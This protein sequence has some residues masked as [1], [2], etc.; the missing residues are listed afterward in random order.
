MPSRTTLR[1]IPSPVNRRMHPLFDPRRIERDALHFPEQTHPLLTD[2]RER[3]I[4]Y[5]YLRTRDLFKGSFVSASVEMSR[6]DD[7]PVLDLTL[8]IDANWETIHFLQQ[9]VL[10]WLSQWAQDWTE[11]ERADYDERIYFRVM[12]RD[13]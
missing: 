8:V 6:E 11:E 10:T 1:H 9:D 7:A 12:P 3:V 13:P 5:I 2:F 4:N